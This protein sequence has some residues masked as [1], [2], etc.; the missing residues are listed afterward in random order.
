MKKET[1]LS[2][3]S[4]QNYCFD[5]LDIEILFFTHHQIKKNLQELSI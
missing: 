2:K 5:N 4:K 1:Y 3:N